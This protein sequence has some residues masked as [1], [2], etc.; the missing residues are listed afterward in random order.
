MSTGAE[1]G[2]EPRGGARGGL[3]W[4]G[5]LHCHQ[6]AFLR[7]MNS[8]KNWTSVRREACRFLTLIPSW[9]I[10]SLARI[11]LQLNVQFKFTVIATPN[12]PKHTSFFHTESFFREGYS[13]YVFQI[14]S[15]VGRKDHFPYPTVVPLNVSCC[16]PRGEWRRLWSSSS[17]NNSVCAI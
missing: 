7:V 8:S 5:P 15:L 9:S 11:F 13:I 10:C 16:P 6:R 2:V 4:T 3:E 12:A 14:P 17:L 1:S